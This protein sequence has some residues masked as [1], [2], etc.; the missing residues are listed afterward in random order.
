MNVDTAR[1]KVRRE[2]RY[3]EKEGTSRMKIHS[4]KTIGRERMYG[5]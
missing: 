5:E 4:R 3:G 1:N 2:R